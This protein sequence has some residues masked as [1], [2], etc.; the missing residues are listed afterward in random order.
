MDVF[1]RSNKKNGCLNVIEG[2]HKYGI[3]NFGNNFSTSMEKKLKKKPKVI[4]LELKP[5]EAVLFSNYTVHGSNKN[6]TKKTD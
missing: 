6:K 1:K 4:F 3:L 2:S 5:G